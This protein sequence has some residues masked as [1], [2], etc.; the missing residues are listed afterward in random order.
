MELM[1]LQEQIVQAQLGLQL[2]DEEKKKQEDAIDNL[3]I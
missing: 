1:S 3:S 2:S